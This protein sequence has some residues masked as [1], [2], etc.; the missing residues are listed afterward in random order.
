[1]NKKIKC[2]LDKKDS[3]TRDEAAKL[4]LYIVELNQKSYQL[5]KKHKKN[6]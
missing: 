3:L 1:M 6:L 4:F 2:I 5:I